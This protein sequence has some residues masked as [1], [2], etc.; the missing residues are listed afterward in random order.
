MDEK[1]NFS[2]KDLLDISKALKN[3]NSL[4]ESNQKTINNFSIDRRLMSLDKNIL[5]GNKLLISEIKKLNKSY[6]ENTIFKKKDPNAK[7]LNELEQSNL[8]AKENMK[9]QK[10]ILGKIKDGSVI[11]GNVL[12][13]GFISGLLGYLMF[14]DKKLLLDSIRDIGSTIANIGGGLTGGLINGDFSKVGDTVNEL[15]KD[16]GEG[17]IGQILSGKNKPF[18]VLKGTLEVQGGLFQGL[19]WGNWDLFFKGIDDVKKNL[20]AG[21]MGMLGAILFGVPLAKGMLSELGN[22]AIKGLMAHPT[23]ALG[24]AT[25]LAT[26][27]I[28]TAVVKLTDVIVSKYE[29]KKRTEKFI[30]GNND[31]IGEKYKEKGFSDEDIKTLQDI[32]STLLKLS[33]EQNKKSDKEKM[34]DIILKN[35]L[36]QKQQEIYK[37]YGWNNSP[38]SGTVTQSQLN[39]LFVGSD[40]I[41]SGLDLNVQ[42]N[43]N[44]MNDAYFKKTG[45]HIKINSGFR[46]YD[47]QKEMYNNAKDKKYVAKPG[48]SYHEKGLALD[49]D[50]DI[51]NELD[52]MG[53][54]KEYGFHRPLNFEPWHIEPIGTRKLKLLQNKVV[55]LTNADN[56]QPKESISNNQKKEIQKVEIGE[57]SIMAFAEKVATEFIRKL[58][59]QN[60][61]GVS[62]SPIIV[63]K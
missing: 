31:L 6:S 1:K 39:N 40:N 13:F 19:I 50:R 8:F 51:V 27:C 57:K 30:K 58:P 60:G 49:I 45:K 11:L 22:L 42:S 46:T 10:S 53:L 9:L 48:T 26:G 25:V 32:N 7:L 63:R 38:P 61:S 62:S 16:F 33:S 17:L 12:K 2:F 37:K 20:T 24:I 23:I 44:K 5:Q 54:L 36:R 15:Y 28:M 29:S 14:G 52:E 59:N 35:T 47:E 56:N 55:V 21:Q 18:N 43:F 41:H 34:N 3:V 4:K